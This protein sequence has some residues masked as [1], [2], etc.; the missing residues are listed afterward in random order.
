V[1]GAAA[2]VVGGGVTLTPNKAKNLSLM[3]VTSMKL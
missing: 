3:L 2:G 1:A